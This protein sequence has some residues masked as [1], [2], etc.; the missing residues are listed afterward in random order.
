[1]QTSTPK[2]EDYVPM[3]VKVLGF[4]V[5]L[6]VAFGANAEKLVGRFF[7]MGDPLI[8]LSILMG[9]LLVGLIWSIQLTAQLIKQYWRNSKWWKFICVLAS[10]VS[11]S[12]SVLLVLQ[13]CQVREELKPLPSLLSGQ[14]K[15][16][17][18]SDD[19][20]EG[21]QIQLISTDR[22]GILSGIHHAVVRKGGTYTVQGPE[23]MPRN[24]W[25]QI[26]VLTKGNDS[27]TS[28]QVA[29][30]F[31]IPV[32]RGQNIRYEVPSLTNNGN[33]VLINTLE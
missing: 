19:Y 27:S 21:A 14:I 31:L 32:K 33:H 23:I 13:V 8:P 28:N 20:L 22:S 3:W 29:D 7:P 9:L 24:A 5:T 18:Q 4:V 25:L 12:L 30:I 15:D 6:L 17:S 11:L 26:R 10:T 16:I 2:P 1:M